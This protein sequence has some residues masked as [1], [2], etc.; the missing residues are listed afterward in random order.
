MLRTLKNIPPEELDVNEYLLS[1]IG[2][3]RGSELGFV[4]NPQALPAKVIGAVI[5]AQTAKKKEEDLAKR[6]KP[7]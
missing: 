3:M 2:Q 4:E 1:T 7:E 5:A 6:A